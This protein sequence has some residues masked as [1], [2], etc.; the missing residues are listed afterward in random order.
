M[1]LTVGVGKVAVGGA[2]D[3]DMPVRCQA[4][5]LSDVMSSMAGK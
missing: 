3:L 5:Q 4:L 2:R 1:A